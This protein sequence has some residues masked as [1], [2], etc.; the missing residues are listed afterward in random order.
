MN[1]HSDVHINITV[2]TAGTKDT[3]E[4]AIPAPVPSLWARKLFV[5]S[6]VSSSNH[7][8]PQD[9]AVAKI[10]QTTLSNPTPHF[11]P[12]FR[13]R[14]TLEKAE[15]RS[16]P[17]SSK[18]ADRTAAIH[19]RSFASRGG[20]SKRNGCNSPSRLPHERQLRRQ[21]RH[22]RPQHRR[23]RPLRASSKA[24]NASRRS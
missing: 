12:N 17:V 6:V 8:L 16:G 23:D 1:F 20:G 7:V 11:P 18:A 2:G 4:A 3:P 15:Q 10:I 24:T 5:S 14:A 19:G 9:T 13:W 21:E 22:Q